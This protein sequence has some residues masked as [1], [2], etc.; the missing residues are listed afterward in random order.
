MRWI[1]YSRK[2]SEGSE[3]QMQSIP[4][5]NSV[6]H[7]IE[8]EQHLTIAYKLEEA[9]SAKMPG[10]RPVFAEMIRLIENGKADGILCWHLN[11]LS[12][13]PV[14]A[15]KLSW[16]LQQGILK[17]IKTPF[18][19][20]HPEDNVLIMAVE[21]ADAN[22]YVLEL[23][24]NIR[25]GQ[26]EKA[27][28]GWYPRKPPG[29]Y[30]TNRDTGEIEVD[31]ERFPL[32]RRA[33]ELMLTGAYPV[34]DL[35]A[36][37]EG[38]GYTT[39]RLHR[40]SLTPRPGK[41]ISRSNLYKLFDNRFYL[42]EFRFEGEVHR[43]KHTPMVSQEEFAQVQEIIHGVHP[44][45]PMRHVFAY[46]GLIR[47]G[48]CGCMVTAE[49]K[50][51]HYRTTNRTVSYVYYHCTRTKICSEPAVT[52]GYVV[53]VLKEKLARCRLNPAAVEWAREAILAQPEALESLPVMLKRDEAELKTVRSKLEGLYE[54]RLNGELTAD[55]LKSLKAK[56][57]TQSDRL[58]R[59]IERLAHLGERNRQ[60]ISNLLTYLT[61]A[62]ELFDR[63][64]DKIKRQ[65]ARLLADQYVLTLGELRVQ[66]N[67]L[68]EPL[69]TLEPLH[70]H[71]DMVRTGT[72]T[73]ENPLLCSWVDHVR[74][75]LRTEG[76]SFGKLGEEEQAWKC[77]PIVLPAPRKTSSVSRKKRRRPTA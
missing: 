33:W 18:R 36:K 24:R 43:G 39:R 44:S 10:I 67:R 54:L 62:D 1:R 11:R 5:Q 22:N 73:P 49:R 25:R 7:R 63:G 41:M 37:L 4:D 32:L 77:P 52:E 51:K 60:T 72:R 47:C 59:S 31:P 8:R 64:D 30:L 15:G 35:H 23:R 68:L 76:V 20:Y 9:R 55:E 29:G 12:R 53:G 13:N 14:D 65:I 74:T 27:A 45:Q 19:E 75:L 16:L 26:A 42:G 58:E 50:T 56:Y 6:L 70:E 2:S 21:N 66:P 28:R 48:G 61:T 34:P 40:K 38:W 57:Q 69:I 3:S 17:C 46:T 71:P